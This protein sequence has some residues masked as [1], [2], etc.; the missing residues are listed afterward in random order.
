MQQPPPQL[1]HSRQSSFDSA[2]QSGS[3]HLPQLHPRPSP[4]DH[5]S[6]S[7]RQK[8]AAQISRNG[9]QSKMGSAHPNF[10]GPFTVLGSKV[11]PTSLDMGYHTMVNGH[12][13]DDESPANSPTSNVVAGCR[14]KEKVS[15]VSLDTKQLIASYKGSR[16]SAPAACTPYFALLPDDVIVRIF[17]ML[18]A[19]SLCSCAR[20]C[21]RFY[22]LAWEPDLWRSIT[23]TG[24]DSL[25]PI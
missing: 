23:F 8:V 10:S 11:S 21:R 18:P 6:Y 9:T 1:P 17:S 5:G 24:S 19:E 25:V 20:V 12:G 14:P 7:L 2:K 22:F 4:L 16:A 13:K 15:P 3:L